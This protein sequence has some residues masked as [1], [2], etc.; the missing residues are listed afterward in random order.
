MNRHKPAHRWEE[1][2]IV[3]MVMLMTVIIY[4]LDE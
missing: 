2:A 1:I 3:F 4:L